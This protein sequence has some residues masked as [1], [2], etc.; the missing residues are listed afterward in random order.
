MLKEKLIIFSAAYIM[1]TVADADQVIL[2]LLKPV[3]FLLAQQPCF[4]KRLQVLQ[5]KYHMGGPDH[6]LDITKAAAAL[7]NM[8][9]KEVGVASVLAFAFCSLLQHIIKKFLAP[10]F[11]I[12]LF[13]HF[14]KFSK[15]CCRTNQKPR[16][17]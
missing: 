13:I 12:G 11:D 2:G 8:R 3:E 17:Q 10:S 6:G 15:Q 4:I 1:Q 5:P 9:L 16:V 14:C 7:F